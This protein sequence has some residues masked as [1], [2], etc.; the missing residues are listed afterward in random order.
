MHGDKVSTNVGTVSS[1]CLYHPGNSNENFT[2]FDTNRI[3]L[4]DDLYAMQELSHL[5]KITLPSIWS[6]ITSPPIINSGRQKL[7]CIHI[8]TKHQ[9]L[10]RITKLTPVARFIDTMIKS[11]NIHHTNTSLNSSHHLDFFPSSFLPFAIS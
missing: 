3:R 2:Y 4:L 5:D 10:T 9:N 8:P 6:R 11:P 7:S 1:F